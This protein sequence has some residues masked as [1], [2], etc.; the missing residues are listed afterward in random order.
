VQSAEKAL[1]KL[2]EN[3]K[4]PPERQLNLVLSDI[5]MQGMSGKEG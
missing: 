3:A 2:V 1:E 4:L 5:V